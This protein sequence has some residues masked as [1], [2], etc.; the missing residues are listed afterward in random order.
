[1]IKLFI[2]F[3]PWMFL[4]R[5]LLGSVTNYVLSNASC[6]VTIIKDPNFKH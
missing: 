2:F 6:P 5:I 1:M 4:C 3:V